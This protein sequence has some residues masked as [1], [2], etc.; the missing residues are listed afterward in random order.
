MTDR[1]TRIQLTIFAIVTAI[2]VSLMAIFYLRM[3]AALGVGTYA[4]TADFA[5]GGA[6]TRTRTSPTAASR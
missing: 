1:L 2:T 6:Y 3:P 4:V 5:A